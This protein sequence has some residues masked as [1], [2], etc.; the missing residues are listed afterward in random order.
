MFV[1]LC[2]LALGLVGAYYL[3]SQSLPDYDRAVPV[4]GLREPVEIVRTSAAVPHISSRDDLSIYFGL[5]YAHTQDR[6]WQMLILRRTVQGRLAELFGAELADTDEVMRHLGLNDA[7]YTSLAVQSPQA[8]SV[9]EAYASGVNARLQEISTGAHGRGAPELLLFRTAIAPWQPADTL[10]I[11][12]LMALRQSH[13]IR[14]EILR[15]KTSLVVSPDRLVDILPD[16]PGEGAA[17]YSHIAPGLE[18]KHSFERMQKQTVHSLFPL[19]R[20]GMEGASNVWAASPER[21]AANGALLANDPHTELSAPSTWYLVRLGLSTGDLIGATVPGIPTVALGRSE[22][23]GWG[24]TASF[25]DDQDLYLEQLNPD[26]PDE[27]LTPEGYKAFETASSIIQ[28]KGEPSRTI[29]LRRTENGPVLPGHLHELSE[30]TPPGHVMSVA[31]PATSPRDT[32]FSAAIDFSHAQD[33]EAAFEAMQGHISPSLNLVV[34]EPT[35]I[36]MQLIGAAP[37]RDPLHQTKGRMPSPGWNPKNRWSG[38]FP[39]T[40]HPKF[41]DPKGGILGNTNNKII[42]QPFPRHISYDWGD[43]QRVL[44]WQRIMQTRQIHTR[45]SF[46]EAQLDTVSPTART[47]LPLIGGDLWF[48]GEAAPSG[49]PEHLR[50]KALTMLANWNGEMNEH[51]PEPLIY[52]AWLRALQIRLITDDLGQL[53]DEF[54]HVEPLFIERVFRNIEGASVWCDIVQSTKIETCNEIAEL[55]LDDA[56]VWLNETYAQP[57]ESLRWGDAHQARHDHPVLGEVPL[58]AWF[59]NIRQST[60]GGDHTL[61][62]GK[63]VAEGPDPFLNVHGAGYRGVYDFADP[64]SS[65][66]VISTGQSG[67]PLSRHYEDLGQLWRRG[68]YISM[69]LD[70]TLSRT[71][72]LG[73][74]QL[75]P[76]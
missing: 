70:P 72:S 23:I 69:S 42:A 29:T 51:L 3:V 33:I 73:V 10:A 19:P 62:R 68:D 9:L 71:A 8:M 64:D 13:H 36:A 32:S 76:Q 35:R 46:I 60:S 41:I 48:T 61:M 66:F 24:I 34:V 74:T 56:L 50:H 49:T 2:L 52:S 65:V 63:T 20:S 6:L 14:S 67:H 18:R 43:S 17:Q 26:N 59:V 40:E 1:A 5:G 44:R 30:I 39:Y 75:L 53:A 37:L 22:R 31:W 16:I 57:M 15:A 7:A 4:P 27:Y 47:L 58:L 11:M 25:L 12:K 54:P 28:I 45:N 21:S 55:A 38:Y